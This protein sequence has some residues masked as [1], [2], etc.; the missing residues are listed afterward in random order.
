MSKELTYQ[1]A[2][3]EVEQIIAKLNDED[4]DIDTLSEQVKKAT[5]LLSSCREKLAK[6]EQDLEQVITQ[7]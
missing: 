7:G 5:S 6:A 4:F 2:M 3:L 1:Q